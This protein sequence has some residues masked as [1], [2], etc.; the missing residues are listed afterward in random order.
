MTS[1]LRMGRR[2]MVVIYC[3]AMGC[4]SHAVPS[5]PDLAIDPRDFYPLH[6]GNAWSYDVDT[7]EDSTTL[8]V[9]H[10]DAFDGR[11][12]EVR[13]GKAVVRYE[14]GA[15]G[16]RIPSEQAWLLRAPLREGATWVSRGHRTAKVMSTRARAKTSAGDFD[17]CIEIVETGGELELQI[18]TVY[19][20]GVGPVSVQSTMRSKVSERTLT[21]S[22]RL[23]G[24]EVTP[25]SD[26]AR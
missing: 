16:I 8:A 1:R 22:A 14:V 13:T 24:Y 9:T 17:G 5:G 11:V 15:K 4:A 20:P 26:P 18:T 25:L 12:A 10:V 7:G 2:P 6:E 3:L 23:R 19:C 21:V